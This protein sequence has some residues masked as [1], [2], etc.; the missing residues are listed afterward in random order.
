MTRRLIPSIPTPVGLVISKRRII[1][2]EY[3]GCQVYNPLNN[4]HRRIH[5]WITQRMGPSLC[6]RNTYRN[7]VWP[8]V[9]GSTSHFINCKYLFG[10]IAGTFHIFQ[11][12]LYVPLQRSF[13]VAQCPITSIYPTSVKVPFDSRKSR[14]RCLLGDS[15]SNGTKPI[16]ILFDIRKE[17][18]QGE[19]GLPSQ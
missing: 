9:T 18:K 4:K 3:E 1:S 8:S 7:I 10:S 19:Y 13:S 12:T 16:F 14:S 6:T 11:Q 2:F 5:G 17:W 15:L